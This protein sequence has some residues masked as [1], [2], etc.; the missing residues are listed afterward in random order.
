[1]QEV[2]ITL[3]NLYLTRNKNKYKNKINKDYDGDKMITK[4]NT[5]ILFQ[6][7]LDFLKEEGTKDSV[8]N[9]YKSLK[10][11]SEHDYTNYSIADIE[12]MLINQ[13]I[14]SYSKF[15]IHYRALSSYLKYIGNI[16]LYDELNNTYMDDLWFKIKPKTSGKYISYD[17]YL[18]ICKDIENFEEYN[19][20]YQLTLFQCV[21]EGIYCGDFSVLYNL[22]ASDVDETNNIVTLRNSEDEMYT[23]PI[24]N[25]LANNLITLSREPYW[26]SKNRNCDE[27]KFM[28]KGNFADSCLKVVTRKENYKERSSMYL[29]IIKKVSDEYTDKKLSAKRIFVSGL[30][31]RIKDELDIYNITLEDAFSFWCAN[32]IVHKII[33]DICNQYHYCENQQGINL[34]RRMLKGFIEELK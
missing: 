18:T 1:M 31:K 15:I 26:Y 2:V 9:V 8:I 3:Q 11:L 12:N 22:R 27:C 24:S 17:D 14:T 33:N 19:A 7:F 29:R 16:R 5:D 32:R 10:W 30:I 6:N 21:Y 4:Q 13:K 34:L 25:D 23:I 20:L 28:M